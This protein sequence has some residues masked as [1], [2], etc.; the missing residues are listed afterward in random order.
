MEPHLIDLDGAQPLRYDPA[1]VPAD[2]DNETSRW[3]LQTSPTTMRIGRAA[4]VALM[5]NHAIAELTNEWPEADVPTTTVKLPRIVKTDTTYSATEGVEKTLRK[6]HA[7]AK[8]RGTIGKPTLSGGALADGLCDGTYQGNLQDSQ[9]VAA[10]VELARQVQASGDTLRTI[11]I[12][13][14]RVLCLRA[15]APNGVRG[16]VR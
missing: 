11:T 3:A 15:G 4:N 1:D 2:P 16:L 14:Q 6:T 9:V 7:S 12:N 8:G 10:F 13:M 5:H